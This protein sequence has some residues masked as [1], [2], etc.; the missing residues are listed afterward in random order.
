MRTIAN[1]LTSLIVA[2]WIGVIAI[3][4]IQNFTPVSLRF[5]AFES[6]QLPLGIV[7]AFGVGVGLIG[8]AIA[9][10]LWQLASS[11]QTLAGDDEF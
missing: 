1:L 4:A 3:V 9:P 2:V 8:G 11:Q 6:I 5:L 10:V 7:L